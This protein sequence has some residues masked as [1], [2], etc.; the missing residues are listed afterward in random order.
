MRLRRR[1]RTLGLW[2]AGVGAAISLLSLAG[3][4]GYAG[5]SFIWIP[6]DGFIIWALATQRDA[7][8]A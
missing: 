1:G 7:F 2:L 6:I 3:T 5:A 4:T 8:P